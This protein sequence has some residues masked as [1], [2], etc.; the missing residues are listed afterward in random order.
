VLA[1][2][3]PPLVLPRER[4]AT[5]SD[6]PRARPDFFCLQ[7]ARGVAWLHGDGSLDFVRCGAPNRCDYCAMCTACENAVVLR[8]DSFD[9]PDG[10]PRVGITTTTRSP[11]PDW[12]RLREAERLLWRQL[13]R[14]FGRATVQYCGFVEWTTGR[15]ATSKGHRFAHVHHLVKGVPPADALSLESTI[16]E[17][18]RDKTGAW[19]VE[20]RPLFTPM[21][22][23]AYLVLHHH[24]REQGP[25]AG[26]KHVKRL[27]PSRGY[28]GRP[29]AEL[30]WQARELLREEQLYAELV[31]VLGLPDK[32]PSYLVEDLIAEHIDEARERAKYDRPELVH[33]RERPVLDRASGEVSYVF[34]GVIGLVRDRR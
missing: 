25:P 26:T 11:R 7:P 5:G 1:A 29:V 21:G 14:R 12:E 9:R 20:C 15:S 16:S 33:V 28:F 30:R 18:W 6:D 22:A 2:A 4:S 10:F 32:L 24:K 27:R 23:I 31:E 19:R 34:E 8:L 17:W 13:R 3:T